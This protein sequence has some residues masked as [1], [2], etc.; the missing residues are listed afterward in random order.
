MSVGQS[1]TNIWLYLTPKYI[2]LNGVQAWKAISMRPRRGRSA[3]AASM[4]HS[5]P[6]IAPVSPACSVSSPYWGCMI[7]QNFVFQLL[8]GGQLEDASRIQGTQSKKKKKGY[9]RLSVNPVFFI[10][11]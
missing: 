4:C 2:D 8:K 7:D 5:Q 10:S 1:I 9:I 3:M 11:G 6:S